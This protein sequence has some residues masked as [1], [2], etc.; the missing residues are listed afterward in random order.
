[1]RLSSMW[2]CLTLIGCASASGSSDNPF[3]T[4]RSRAP[5]D[6][7]VEVRVE[8]NAYLDMHIYVVYGP[9]QQRS[10]GMV[11]G[12]SR[13]TLVI[14]AQ[15]IQTLS[16]IQL[17]ADPIGTDR[18]FL[19]QPILAYPGQRVRFT[20]QNLLSLSTAWVEGRVGR[21]EDED[22]EADAE[23]SEDEETDEEEEAEDEEE[24][25]VDPRTR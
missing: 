18:G 16:G 4:S 22:E 20:I 7:P 23:E 21:D 1:M 9:G 17:L 14:P 3:A 5:R 15:V 19:S 11:T 25:E 12:L 24:V 6:G 13:R 10:L 2:L 8:N